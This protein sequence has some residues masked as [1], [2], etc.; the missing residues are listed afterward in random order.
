[1][2]FTKFSIRFV[3]LAQCLF[4]LNGLL[5]SSARAQSS[6]QTTN[7]TASKSTTPSKVV[8]PERNANG[9]LVVAGSDGSIDS[10]LMVSLLGYDPIALFQSMTESGAPKGFKYTTYEEMKKLPSM[11]SLLPNQEAFCGSDSRT[12]INTTTEVPWRWNCKLVI[13]LVDGRK[14]VG[15]GF[16]G[17]K[18]MVVTKAHNISVLRGDRFTVKEFVKTVEVIPGMNGATRP[19]GTY[20]A[21]RPFYLPNNW[22]IHQLPEYDYGALEIPSL[23]GDRAGYYGLVSLSDESLK[24][25]TANSYGYPTDKPTGTQWGGTGTVTRAT[26]RQFFHTIDISNGQNGSAIYRLQNG[27]RQAVGIQSFSGCPNTATRINE[28]VLEDL[29]F[30]SGR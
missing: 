9:D 14:F 25:M 29:L 24:N 1:M 4:L 28:Q 10:H 17:G 6:A 7:S 20:V 30:W 15:T 8:K 27:K 23:L 13:T 5:L 22:W 26:S 19:Y 11:D 3:L 18:N 2:N 21:S 16:L 12:R